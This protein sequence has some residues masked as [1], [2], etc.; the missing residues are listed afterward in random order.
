MANGQAFQDAVDLVRA[1]P[2]LGVGCH[3]TIVGGR[4][5]ADRSSVS[6]LVDSEGNFPATLT[7]LMIKLTRG[8]ALA[9]E[10]ANE[11][12]AQLECVVGAGIQPTHLDTHKHSHTHAEVMK[13][14]AR[15]AGEFGIKCIRNPFEG[16][17]AGARLG[18]LSKWAYVKQYALSAAVQPGALQFNRLA[19]AHGLKTP[20]RFYGVGLTGMLDSAAIRSMMESLSEG[21]TELMCHP[22]VCDDDLERAPTRLKREREQE[23]EALSDPELKEFAAERG[24][25]LINFGGL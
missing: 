20:D 8:A 17:L 16:L 23:L 1:N 21:T 3:M 19:R 25:E 12:R 11:F 9:D 15:V 7:K 13:A 2:G 24:I 18:S 14:L 22:G 6:S 5:V 10:I 4:P